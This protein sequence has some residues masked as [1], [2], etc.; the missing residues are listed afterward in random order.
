MKLLIDKKNLHDLTRYGD[1][2][3][4]IVRELKGE[5]RVPQNIFEFVGIAD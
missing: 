3:Y 4:E 1:S 2:Q 5:A